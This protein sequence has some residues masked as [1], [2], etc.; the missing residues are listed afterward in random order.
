VTTVDEGSF[1]RKKLWKIT[2]FSKKCYSPYMTK[3]LRKTLDET[4]HTSCPGTHS[5]DQ[6]GIELRNLSASASR[7]LGLKVCAVKPGTFTSFG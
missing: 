2:L 5:V 1:Q 4:P 6:A 3:S 7:V